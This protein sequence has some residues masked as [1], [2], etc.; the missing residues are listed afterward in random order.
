[1]PSVT[2]P[3]EALGIPHWQDMEKKLV[4]RLD[5][6]LMPM[7]WVLYLFNYLDRAS[8]AQARLSTFEEDLGLTGT[9]LLPGAIYIMSCWYTRK[10]MA[11][12]T[13]ILYTGLVLAMASSGF[14]AAG[15]YHG[16]EGSRGMAGW[17]WLFT[18][19]ALAGSACAGLALFLL[20]NYPDSTTGSAR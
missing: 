6:T 20:P 16:I 7:L 17:Q 2:A 19:L 8:I 14:V 5:M 9:P 11:L 1:M 15:V 10:E 3:I 12:R 18:I 13:A 4:K